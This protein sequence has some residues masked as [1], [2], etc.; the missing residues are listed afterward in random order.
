MKYGVGIDV[1]KAWL[2]VHVHALNQTTRVPNTPS[3]FTRLV[4]WLQPFPVERVVLEATGGY[5]QAALDALFDAGFAVVRVNP[6]QARDFAKACG[7][8]SK[9][10]RLDARVLAQM[11]QVLPL[12]LYQP[13]AAW[14]RQLAEYQ[15]RRLQLRVTLQQERQ[16]T[17]RLTD[18]WLREQAEQSLRHW[19]T[20]LKAMDARLAELIA[21]QPQAAVLR[22]IKGVGPVLIATLLGQLP[23][24][25]RLD[26]KAI[27]KRVGVAPLARDSGMMRGQRSVWG[28]RA[29]IRAVLYMSTLSTI[30]YEPRLR[31]FYQSLRQRGKKAKVAIV[32][33]MR[34]L[35]VILNARMRDQINGCLSMD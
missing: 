23:E 20:L 31:E 13:P 3:G 25:G 17:S 11:A 6:R 35:L 9:T 16:R 14:Q 1:S 22:S 12:P 7:Q 30:R 18:P 15:Q 8:L 5:E 10:D 4:M 33:T 29:N 26:G 28:G 21:E 2:D 19:Q 34:K 24:L 32:A 27:A